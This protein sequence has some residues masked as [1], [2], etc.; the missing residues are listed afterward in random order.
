MALL[1]NPLHLWS[2]SPGGE[3]P[4]PPDVN[5]SVTEGQVRASSTA[6]G[7]VCSGQADMLSLRGVQGWAELPAVAPACPRWKMTRRREIPQIHR[8]PGKPNCKLLTSAALRF[9]R[10]YHGLTVCEAV[11]KR[12]D[13]LRLAVNKCQSQQ[14]R[15]QWHMMEVSLFLVQTQ[16]VNS[17][18][19]IF[20]TPDICSFF[21]CSALSHTIV[22]LF[23]L[24][25]H[26]HWFLLV[27]W[28]QQID[29]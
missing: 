20:H 4:E 6:P 14:A 5:L 3:L 8:R 2:E 23:W 1:S 7:A 19:F 13:C 28:G 15:L 18:H 10:P 22:L 11:S 12:S 26:I 29:S 25:S 27:P 9:N 24:T 21:C 16:T 17:N